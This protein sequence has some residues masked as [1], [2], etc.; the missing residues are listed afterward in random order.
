[1]MGPQVFNDTSTRTIDAL[2]IAVP[3][4]RF[5]QIEAGEASLV[6]AEMYQY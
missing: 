4:A 5:V 3:G 6:K 1:M 2:S